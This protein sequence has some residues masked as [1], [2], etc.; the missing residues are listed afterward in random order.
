MGDPRGMPR[1]S[2]LASVVR[3]YAAIDERNAIAYSLPRGIVYFFVFGAYRRRQHLV[4]DTARQH[5]SRPAST[6]E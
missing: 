4:L 6:R 1:R 5:D 2:S 3:V